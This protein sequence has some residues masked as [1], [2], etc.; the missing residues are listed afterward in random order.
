MPHMAHV[1]LDYISHHTY[2]TYW[3]MCLFYYLSEKLGLAS[4]GQACTL[5]SGLG[6]AYL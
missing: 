1:I 6:C 3:L 4:V 2:C 5:H